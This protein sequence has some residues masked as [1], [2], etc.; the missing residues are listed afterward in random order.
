MM[1][2]RNFDVYFILMSFS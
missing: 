2:F 1:F